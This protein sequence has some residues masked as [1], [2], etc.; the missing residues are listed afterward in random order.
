[1]QLISASALTLRDANT[2][3]AEV[4]M[5]IGLFI[6]TIDGRA[7]PVLAGTAVAAIIVEVADHSLRMCNHRQR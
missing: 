3:L 7:V 6:I 4:P 1:M 5:D 2:S